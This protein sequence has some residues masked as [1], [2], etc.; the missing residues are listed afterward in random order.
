MTKGP[1]RAAAI[2]MEARLADVSGNI[3]QACD[4]AD[5]AARAGARYIALPEFFTTQIALDDRLHGCALPFDNSATRALKA[6]AIANGA[7]IGGSFLEYDAGDVFNTYVLFTPEGVVHTHLKDLPTMAECAYYLGGNDRGLADLGDQTVGIAVCWETIRS[8]TVRRLRG[9]CDVIMSGSHWWSSPE[10]I[11]PSPYLRYHARLNAD[12]MYRTPGR[13]ARMVG[14]PMLHGAHCG[15]LVGR[16]AITPR[17]SLDM[18]TH[19]VGEAQIVNASGEIV[20][21]R[22]RDEGAGI[23]YADI[24][25]GRTKPADVPPERFWL[26]PLPPLIRLMWTTQNQVCRKVYERARREG[27]IKVYDETRNLQ[28]AE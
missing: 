22:M 18:K 28:V 7:V 20:A 12:L 19:L 27:R 11:V 9:A 10:W 13:F 23:V 4:L 14:A 17:F 3:A 21:R 6:L 16:Y 24:V 26:E 5:R 25:I 2:Q 8:A 1:V 15:S